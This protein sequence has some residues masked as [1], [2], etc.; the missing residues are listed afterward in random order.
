MSEEE[1]QQWALAV[2]MSVEQGKEQGDQFCSQVEQHDKQAAALLRSVREKTA[3]LSA[4]LQQR[5]KA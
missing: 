3:E 5:F 1:F 4:H 2:I